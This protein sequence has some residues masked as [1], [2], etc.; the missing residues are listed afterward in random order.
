MRRQLQRVWMRGGSATVADVTRV[1]LRWRLDFSD[2]VTDKHILFSSKE[3]D[4]REIRA[5]VNACSRSGVFVDIGANTGYYTVRLASAGV[6]V[7]ALEPNPSAYHRM[8]F[9][10][11]L[12]DLADRVTAMPVGCGEEGEAVLY[13]DDLSDG[14]TVAP[15]PRA[16]RLTI[17][18]LP[19]ADILGSQGVKAIDALKIDVEGAEDRALVPFFRSASRDA[20]PRCVVIEENHREQWETDIIELMLDRGYRISVRARINLVLRL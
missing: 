6:R 12:N 16:N 7:L 1:G 8:L 13:F 3:H 20:W 4:R 15:A 18:T 9:N 5:I 11:R 14:S 17:R 10:V 19:L 2:N